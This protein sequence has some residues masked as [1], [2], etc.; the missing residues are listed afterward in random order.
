MFYLRS[1]AVLVREMAPACSLTA[2]KTQP[3][4]QLYCYIYL[5]LSVG[6]LLRVRRS[7]K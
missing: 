5:I 7:V 6:R 4:V 3:Q 2:Y 1:T